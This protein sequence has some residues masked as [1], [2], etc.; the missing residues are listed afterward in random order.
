MIKSKELKKINSWSCCDNFLAK[1]WIVDFRLTFGNQ[2]V[3]LC[4]FW[5]A[6]RSI[7]IHLLGLRNTGK[8][9]EDDIMEQLLLPLFSQLV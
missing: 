2:L 7:K 5:E 9:L 1:I 3:S 4:Q 8:G 6:S